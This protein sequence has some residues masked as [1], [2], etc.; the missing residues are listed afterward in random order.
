MT[1][2]YLNDIGFDDT[3]IGVEST[4]KRW[5]DWQ[6]EIK[7]YGFAEYETW[8]LDTSFYAWLYERLKFSLEFT[9]MFH[10]LCDF[11]FEGKKYTLEQLVNKMIHGC[12]I[13]LKVDGWYLDLSEEDKKSIED[14]RWIWATVMPALWW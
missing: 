3:V 14:V 13:A 4:D 7:E 11:E 1:R 9:P 10:V 5:N 2:K 12:E 6:K 8:N